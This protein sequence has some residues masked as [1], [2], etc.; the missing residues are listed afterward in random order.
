MPR[1]PAVVTGASSGSAGR[2]RR[3][4]PRRGHPLIA[5]R[6][7]RRPARG[8]GGM[9]ARSPRGRDP[10]RRRPTSPP[11][12]VSRS[13]ARRS[14]AGGVPEVVVLN[15]GFGSSGPLWTLDRA[16]AVGDGA[17][18]LRRGRRSR[19]PTSLP[20]MVERGRGRPRGHELGRRVA[21]G[22]LHGDLRGDQG[23]RAAPAPRRSPRSCAAPAC[24]RSPS[25][26]DRRAPSSRCPGAGRPRRGI[27]FDDVD[28][29]VRA[30]WRALARGRSRVP[31]GGSS[32]ARPAC[33]GAA[34][35]RVARSCRLGRPHAPPPRAR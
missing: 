3:A 31:T 23:L 29:V 25:A 35:C 19:A 10:D 12:R 26:R 6:A 11:R 8:A 30:T 32:R 14:T 18:Q 16:R 34:C 2:T 20:G 13:A 33:S 28:M 27:P 1:G 24:A 5:R 9:G 21:A 4:S 15:A 17:A 7:P 22:P